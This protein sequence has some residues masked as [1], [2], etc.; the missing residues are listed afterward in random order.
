M[1]PGEVVLITQD[2]VTQCKPP[3]ER[4][5]ICSFFWVYYGSPAS[6]Y[7]G[8]NVEIVRYRCGAALAKRDAIEGF[9]QPNM[10]AGIPGSGIG[11][12]IGYSNESGTPYG[13]PFLKYNET[14]NR[15]FMPQ[16]QKIRD[17][18]ARMKLIPIKKLI[19]GKS[20]LFCDDSIVRGTQLKDT[21]QGLV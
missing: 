11:H 3:N 4:N 7:E 6:S 17:E 13:R 20:L 1:V 8:I 10:V 14:W 15:S 19:K 5:Q 21:I 18:V 16:D 12:G 9:T 2:G